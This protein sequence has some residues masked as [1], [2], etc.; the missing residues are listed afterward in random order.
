MRFL[1]TIIRWD[2]QTFSW[3]MR[4]KHQELLT[5]SS[6]L[7]SSSADGYLYV[8]IGILLLASGTAA[9]RELFIA[10]AIAFG[11]ERAIY[12]VM[13]NSFK[14]NRPPEALPG[15]QSFIVPSD[16]FSFPSGHT[17]GAFL[18][19]TVF[20]GLYPALSVPLYLWGVMIA[21]SRVLLGVHFPT[22]T[23]I[24]ALLGHSIGLVAIASLM[25]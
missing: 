3:C 20:A 7:I 6:R 8:A 2:H 24:G 1:N 23:L 21:S 19:A 15:F 9:N 13:K 18:M 25:S 4:R 22:D 11:T 14:R 10:L 12:W 5:R 16:K 17:S